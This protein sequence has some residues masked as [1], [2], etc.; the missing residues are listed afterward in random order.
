MIIWPK[1][2]RSLRRRWSFAV[3]IMAVV[4]RCL[5]LCP[6]AIPSAG[7]FTCPRCVTQHSRPNASECDDGAQTLPFLWE[8]QK[9][10]NSQ[11]TKK[12]RMKPG[13]YYWHQL[14]GIHRRDPCFPPGTP[15]SREH[16]L[17]AIAMEN[18][19]RV[20]SDSTFSSVRNEP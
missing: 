15:I 16:V 20:V 7:L 17:C 10:L 11:G 12:A 9:Q 4:A 2:S 5:L 13:R 3:V 14:R 18:C 6:L 19:K 1:A 8:D